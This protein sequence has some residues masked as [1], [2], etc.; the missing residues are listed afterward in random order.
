V[1]NG[2][3]EDAPVHV[4]VDHVAVELVAGDEGV[5]NFGVLQVV[6]VEQR[7]DVGL[8]SPYVDDQGLVDHALDLLIEEWLPMDLG[9][10]DILLF[11]ENF[12]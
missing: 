3:E 6:V 7:D 2:V 9:G 12:L 8:A 5:F 1:L 10:A 4:E 11:E